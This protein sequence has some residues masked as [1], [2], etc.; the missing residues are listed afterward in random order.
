MARTYKQ[1][2]QVMPTDTTATSIYSPAAD[3]VTII[4]AITVCNTDSSAHAFRLFH[5]DDGTTYD[6]TTAL[7]YDVSVAANTTK[8]I[9]LSIN[10]NDA[11]GNLAFRSDSANN[12]TCTVYGLEMT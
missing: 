1:L 12:L 2:G 5:D 9:T 4:K 8:E 10:M 6:T 11:S 3:T 7:Y